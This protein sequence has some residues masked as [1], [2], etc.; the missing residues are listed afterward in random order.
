MPT[1]LDQALTE[2]D[3]TERGFVLGALLAGAIDDPDFATPLDAASGLRCQQALAAIAHLSRT[4]RVKLTGQLATD[5]LSVLPVGID[6]VHPDHLRAALDQESASI[7]QL[8]GGELPTF[9]GA[10]TA[11]W[12]AVNAADG[13]PGAEPLSAPELR[14]EVQRSVFAGL[15]EVPPA[16]EGVA[17][18]RWSRQLTLMNPAALLSLITESTDG[19]PA[20]APSETLR[21]RAR[22][23]G[24]RLTDEETGSLGAAAQV[25]AVAQRLPR[26]L[27]EA[28]LE[29]AGG[30]A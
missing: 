5:A 11:A 28:L 26:A 14:T 3:A 15:A 4:E 19:L 10:V 16:W 29:G 17:P 25:L 2:L 21:L 27:A 8:A 13:E 7:V 12:L 23:L 9:I 6:N 22:V 20:V 24:A 1:P 30:A 18:H